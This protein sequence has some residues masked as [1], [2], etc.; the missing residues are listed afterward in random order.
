MG[1][2]EEGRTDCVKAL[3]KP[4]ERVLKEGLDIAVE[5]F[6]RREKLWQQ[7]EENYERYLD[8]ECGEF[9][10][11]LDMHF[12]SKFE[13][14]LALL[15]WSF[16]QNGETYLPASRRYRDRELE[17]LERVLRYNVFEIY[18]MEDILRQIMH[19]DTN[20]LGL[21]REYRSVNTWIEGIL[22]DHSIKLQLRL[23]LKSTWE[24]YKGKITAAM[25]EATQRF[26]W[27]Q[28]VIH[29]AEE[30]TMAVERTYRRQLERKDQEMNELRKQM[31][32][33]RMRFEQEKAELQKRLEAA[34]DEELARIIQEK[35]E[36]RRR[37]EEEKARLVEE[38]SRMKDEEARKMLEEELA[39]MQEKM[40]AEVRAMEEEIKRRELQLREKEM[41]L[42]KRELEIK[43]KEDEISRKIREV[44]NLTG[45]VEKGSRFVKL[46]EARIMEINFIGRIKSKFKDNVKLL[47]MTFKVESVKEVKTFDKTS[48]VGKLNERDLKNVPDNTLV[49]VKLKEKKL[50]GRGKEIMVKALFYGRPERYAEVGFDTDPIELADINALLIDAR[51][52]AKNGRVVLLVASPTGFERRVRSYIDSKDFHRNF[53]SENVSIAL[54]DLESGELLYNPHDEYAKAF[55]PF[56]RLERDEELLAKVKAMLEERVS[57]K[58]YV[59]LEDAVGDFSEDIVKRAFQELKNEKGYVTKFIDG[60]GYVLVKEGFL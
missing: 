56:L 5:S 16:R 11:D 23:F 54:L 17:A 21:L 48:Y 49:E 38:I 31:N 7:V 9:L 3:L 30:E 51:D 47:G 33:M 57:Q 22:Q 27:F 1:L 44:M 8:G 24:S 39:K 40:T 29:E 55:K 4:A 12:R 2:F 58:G 35:E 60:V 36:M 50:L 15:A 59:R 19:R 52:N 26:D 20:I 34:K 37:F 13:G 18:T 10:R 14:A 42:R 41:E 25:A 53:I 46:D 43:E 32:S 28:D 45:K 6:Q